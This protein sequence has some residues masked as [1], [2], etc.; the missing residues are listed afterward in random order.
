MRRRS[1]LLLVA[2]AALV[3]AASTGWWWWS[4][5]RTPPPTAPAPRPP[6]VVRLDAIGPHE[7]RVTVEGLDAGTLAR[8]EQGRFTGAATGR[9]AILSRR[10]TG[11]RVDVLRD[12]RVD[13]ET[14]A[15]VQRLLVF[16]GAGQCVIVEAAPAGQ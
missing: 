2:A 9:L 8:D 13:I 12:P 6:G 5:G 11:R 7:A 3:A 15:Y 14:A 4:R 16:G 10:F 1:V